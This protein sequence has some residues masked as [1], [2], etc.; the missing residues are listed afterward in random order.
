MPASYVHLIPPLFAAAVSSLLAA[1]LKNIS[2]LFDSPTEQEG[3][4]GSGSPSNFSTLQA[5]QAI[6]GQWPS[7]LPSRR[8]QLHY[9]F[10]FLPKSN[11]RSPPGESP[12][13]S[14]RPAGTAGRGGDGQDEEHGALAAGKKLKST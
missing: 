14:T 5:N 2:L 11:G 13:S 12:C 3:Q 7:S 1:T 8:L 4:A 10:L 9:K 6:V